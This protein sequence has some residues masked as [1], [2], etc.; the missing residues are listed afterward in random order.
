MTQTKPICVIYFPPEFEFSKGGRIV[1]TSALTRE[2][3][4]ISE[5]TIPQEDNLFS[6]YLWFC[7]TKE[8]ATE[9]EFQVFSEKNFSD[10]EYS[11][12]RGLVLSHLTKEQLTNP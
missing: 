7:F 9:P 2:L 4:G 1:D 3:N 12:L 5:N 11:E 10:M 8:S 6:D